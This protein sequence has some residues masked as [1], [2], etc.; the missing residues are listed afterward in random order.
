MHELVATGGNQFS[1]LEKVRITMTFITLV[2]IIVL[3]AFLI[4]S[5]M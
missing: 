1:T 2:T 5:G 3:M 4:F